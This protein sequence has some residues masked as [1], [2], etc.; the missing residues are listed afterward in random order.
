M[1][2]IRLWARAFRATQLVNSVA[3]AHVQLAKLFP[4]NFCL[5]TATVDHMT[6]LGRVIAFLRMAIK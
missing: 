3:R 5:L 2:I 1:R 6:T 4:K